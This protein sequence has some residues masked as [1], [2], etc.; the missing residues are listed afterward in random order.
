MIYLWA[1]WGGILRVGGRERKGEIGMGDRLGIIH[2]FHHS[3]THSHLL[4]HLQGH[5]HRHWGFGWEVGLEKE[6]SGGRGVK[7]LLQRG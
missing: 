4:T 2:S 1:I 7:G 5:M 6:R 3:F